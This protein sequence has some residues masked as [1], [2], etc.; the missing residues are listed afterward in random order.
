M[1][2]LTTAAVT[3]DKRDIIYTA[4]WSLFTMWCGD[5]YVR[6]LRHVCPT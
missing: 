3:I 5:M 1:S 6:A 4:F 2:V